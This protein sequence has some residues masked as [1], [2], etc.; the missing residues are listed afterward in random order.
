[1]K[2]REALIAKKQKIS[3]STILLVRKK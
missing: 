1:M 2:K 3:A